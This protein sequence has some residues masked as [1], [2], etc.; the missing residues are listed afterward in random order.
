[1]CAAQVTTHHDAAASGV[2][3]TLSPAGFTRFTPDGTEFLTHEQWEREYLVH[4]QLMQLCVFKQYRLWR[5]MA[6]WRKVVRDHKSAGSSAQLQKALC[7]LK[8]VLREA[9]YATR[10][11]DVLL[12]VAGSLCTLGQLIAGCVTRTCPAAVQQPVCMWCAETSS[13]CTIP[14]KSSSHMHCFWRLSS[15]VTA[16]MSVLPWRLAA[17]PSWSPGSP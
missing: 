7:C 17:A 4:M 5:P 14:V 11:V 12:A 10:W 3:L 2:Y 8:P 6:L 13:S 15:C 1:M 16:G 9:L